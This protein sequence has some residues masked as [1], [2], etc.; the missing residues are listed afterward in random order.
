MRVM[1]NALSLNN[2]SGTGRYAWG[3]IDGFSQLSV[4]DVTLH[5][6]IPVDYIIPK[7]WFACEHIRF[8]SIP[9]TYAVQ[10]IWWEQ[11]HLPKLVDQLGVDLLHSTSFIAPVFR[12]VSARQIITVHDLTF[13]T[14]P[15]TIKGVNKL[16]YQWFIPRSMDRADLIITD[17][18]CVAD[19]IAQ[20]GYGHKSIKAV[21]L[22]VDPARYHTNRQSKDDEVLQQYELKQPYYLFVGTREPRKNLS[23]LLQAYQIARQKG[24]TSELVIVGRMGWKQDESLF[25]QQ[26]IRALG[27]VPEEHLPPLYRHAQALLAP[28]KYEGFDLPIIEALACGTPVIASD[29]PVHREVGQEVATYLP[30]EDCNAW[31]E[32][33]LQPELINS[34]SVKLSGWKDVALNVLDIYIDSYFS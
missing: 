6:L 28:S 23:M 27:H 17:T 8:Y 11:V 14:Y 26:G 3:L 7:K 20:S 1:I 5:V 13:W 16:Y 2:R 32:A 21:H 22:G 18:Q 15:E 33:L 25:S 12:K 31:A 10:R 9:V 30:V 29:I 19:E 34:A 4:N 24:L